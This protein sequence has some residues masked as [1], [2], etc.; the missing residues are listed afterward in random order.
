MVLDAFK[1]GI[2]SS[3]P[4]EGTGNPGLPAHFS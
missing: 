1:S 2:F 3:Y 4:T